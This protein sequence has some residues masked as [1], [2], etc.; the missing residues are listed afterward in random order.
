MIR[1][2]QTDTYHLPDPADTGADTRL[3]PDHRQRRGIDRPQPRE[4]CIGKRVAGDVIDMRRQV[5]NLALGVEKAG[6]F[7]AFRPIT[8]QFHISG[9]AI[10][11]SEKISWTNRRQ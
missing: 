7:L 10:K 4:A 8:K 6:L 5:A 9:S 11:R 1:I 2:V 3:T